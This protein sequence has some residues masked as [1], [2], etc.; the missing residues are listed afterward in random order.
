MKSDALLDRSISSVKSPATMLDDT[1][2]V[3]VPSTV[4]EERTMI[5]S[6]VVG[7]LTAAVVG[8]SGFLVATFKN[9]S[10]VVSPSLLAE[11]VP[12]VL[13]LG[14]AVLLLIVGI[15][16]II[17]AYRAMMDEVKTAAVVAVREALDKEKL[18]AY[19]AKEKAER[20]ANGD[21]PD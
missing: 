5:E 11:Q 2:P 3:R 20:A 8:G 13:W 4:S 19:I 10:E 16:G 6:K 14:G 17:N 9:F 15:K 21:T 12:L 7:A 18:A 1:V